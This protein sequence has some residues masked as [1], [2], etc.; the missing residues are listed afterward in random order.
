MDREGRMLLAMDDLPLQ[1][2]LKACTSMALLAAWRSCRA[3]RLDRL[4]EV[5]LGVHV[6]L[7]AVDETRDAAAQLGK[8]RVLC[9]FLLLPASPM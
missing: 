4:S 7:P 3:L 2:V 5:E 9:E 8:V 6:K 1:L